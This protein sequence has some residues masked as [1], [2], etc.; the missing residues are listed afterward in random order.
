MWRKINNVDIKIK[1]NN[2]SIRC[3]TG[4]GENSKYLTRVERRGYARTHVAKG[5]TTGARPA[6]W[7]KTAVVQPSEWWADIRGTLRAGL[8]RRE[9]IKSNQDPDTKQLF[10]PLVY[11]M[12]YSCLWYSNDCYSV[13]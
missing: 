2:S 8:N 1:Q 12:F 10:H 13:S 9:I 5:P 7:Q 3:F 4:T 6:G 11:M